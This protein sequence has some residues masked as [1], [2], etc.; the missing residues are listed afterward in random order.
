MTAQLLATRKV[1]KIFYDFKELAEQTSGSAI[2]IDELIEEMYEIDHSIV[3]TALSIR[4]ISRKAE[5]LSGD[6]AG[7]LDGELK[8]I[9][10][11]VRSLITISGE[12]E[13]EMGKFKLNS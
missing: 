5:K 4:D 11:G 10:R 7:S 9:Q 1:E 2:S 6:A 13:R 3:E 8:D 12:L